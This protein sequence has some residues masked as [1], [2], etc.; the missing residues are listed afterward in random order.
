[1]VGV[2]V[3]LGDVIWITADTQGDFITSLQVEHP[4]SVQ[5]TMVI[6]TYWRLHHGN[7]SAVN[8][9]KDPPIV[10]IVNLS[11]DVIP[12][13]GRHR[14]SSVVVPHTACKMAVPSTDRPVLDH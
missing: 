4:T 12:S 13:G 8:I 14:Q 1:M 11:V 5:A 2:H 6:S 9:N 3:Y 7:G 10:V